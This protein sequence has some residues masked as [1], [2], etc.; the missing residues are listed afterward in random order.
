MYSNY[1]NQCGR[2]L[3]NTVYVKDCKNPLYFTWSKVFKCCS[4]VSLSERFNSSFKQTL[5][6]I[7]I[8]AKRLG[9][10]RTSPPSLV[11]SC[12]TTS[13]STSV[14]KRVQTTPSVSSTQVLS[15]RCRQKSPSCPSS[16]EEKKFMHIKESLSH[17]L[18]HDFPS[19]S[20]LS[21]SNRITIK[22]SCI[23]SSGG[24][25]AKTAGL[26]KTIRQRACYLL[27]PL[28]RH[29]NTYISIALYQPRN[30]LYYTIGTY[31]YTL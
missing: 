16:L 12:C 30:I 25:D 9:F 27:H 26:L 29:P 7:D 3:V 17:I 18:P 22:D 8:L 21:F 6:H 19:F 2:D 20:S 11:D 10:R 31:K 5:F 23:A 15:H 13:M 1:D 24:A 28:N 14:H 4:W